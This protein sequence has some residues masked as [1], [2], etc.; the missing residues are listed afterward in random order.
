MMHR[1]SVWGKFTFIAIGLG[2][3]TGCAT[4]ERD[5]DPVSWE[6]SR[7]VGCFA[8]S[9][10]GSGWGMGSYSAAHAQAHNDSEIAARD[11]ESGPGNHTM[12][13]ENVRC[14][15]GPGIVQDQK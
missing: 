1:G 5:R 2:L 9:W 3:F 12:W 14:E 8:H 15:K 10:E 4:E 13:Y 11:H 7:L 6:C